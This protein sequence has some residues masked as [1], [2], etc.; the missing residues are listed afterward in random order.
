MKNINFITSYSDIGDWGFIT[1]QM[2]RAI[3]S[4]DSE[5]TVSF[6][7]SNRPKVPA[8][9]PEIT[10]GRSD[11]NIYVGF[12]SSTEDVT[13][14]DWIYLPPMSLS[15]RGTGMLKALEPFKNILVNSPLLAKHLNSVLEGKCFSKYYP[16]LSLEEVEPLNI[17]KL[18]KDRPKVLISGALDPR[19][20]ILEAITGVASSLSGTDVVLIIKTH[21][22]ND[23]AHDPVDLTNRIRAYKQKLQLNIPTF[24]IPDLLSD[25]E[26]IKLVQNCDIYASACKMQDIDTTALIAGYL[27]KQVVLPGGLGFEADCMGPDNTILYGPNSLEPVV[28]GT[29]EIPQGSKVG[30]INLDSLAQ[31]LKLAYKNIKEK[32]TTFSDKLSSALKERLEPN[33]VV[34][35]FTKGLCP[36]SL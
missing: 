35:E 10:M 32:D 7:N 14:N 12:P 36:A 9:M 20:N 25:E 6:S 27:G 18:P 13:D 22:P 24:L 21:A 17:F 3:N 33:R 23:G 5:A 16:P 1:R 26:Y 4:S 28:N 31:A 30:R 11:Q 34:Q 19:K 29:P 8:D 2:V 15:G